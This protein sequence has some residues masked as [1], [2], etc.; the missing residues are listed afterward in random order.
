MN[1]ATAQVWEAEAMLD[2]VSQEGMW[3]QRT[4]RKYIPIAFKNCG[5]IQRSDEVGSGPRFSLSFQKKK[6]QISDTWKA[7]MLAVFSILPPL[8]S[9]NL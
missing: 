2:G 5:G 8:S 1:L 7:Q 6:K 9:N 4:S 3:E